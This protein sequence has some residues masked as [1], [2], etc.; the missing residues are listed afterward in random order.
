[1]EPEKKK[2]I[3]QAELIGMLREHERKEKNMYARMIA[4]VSVI[5]YGLCVFIDSYAAHLINVMH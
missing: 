1:M 4:I 5:F 2:E 3:R